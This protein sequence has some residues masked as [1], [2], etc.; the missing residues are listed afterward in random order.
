MKVKVKHCISVSIILTSE[1]L[2]MSHHRRR[3]LAGGK[4]LINNKNKI[5]PKIEHCGTPDRISEKMIVLNLCLWLFKVRNEDID[6]T[7]DMDYRIY[8]RSPLIKMWL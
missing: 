1:P 2:G 5:G 8:M 4:S 7:E 3:S 6:S